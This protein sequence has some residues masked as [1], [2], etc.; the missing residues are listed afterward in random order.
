MDAL[1]YTYNNVPNILGK[2]ISTLEW[3]HVVSKAST[4]LA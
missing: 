1:H 2:G 3:Q 4:C